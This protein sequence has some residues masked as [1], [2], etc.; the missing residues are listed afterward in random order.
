MTTTEARPVEVGD[1]F[2]A[3]W[4]YDQTNVDFYEVVGITA[5]GKSVKVLPI[6]KEVTYVGEGGST[7]VTPR[8][9]SFDLDAVP[10]TKRVRFYR[11]DAI[12]RISSYANAYR[13]SPDAEQ[14]E[15]ALGFGH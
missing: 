9:G 11:D 13:V 12:I 2:A 10:A 15:T 1:I 14:Y 7:R 5:S 6:G 4:G 3:S 8:P